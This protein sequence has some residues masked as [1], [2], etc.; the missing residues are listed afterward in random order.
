MSND[1]RNEPILFDAAGV[2]RTDE[3]AGI[4][5]KFT[6][7]YDRLLVKVIPE[8]ERTWNG[9]VMPAFAV[10]NCPHLRGEVIASG[11]GRVTQMGDV[12][13]MTIKDGDLIAFYRIPSDQI[14]MP[15][16]P[17]T[18]LM[19]IREHHVLGTY[20]DLPAATGVLGAD[21]RQ[22]VST[23]PIVGADGKGLAS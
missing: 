13:P 10:E 3:T 15:S 17:G 22:V 6:P 20:S 16:A 4:S 21:G 18:E 1:H 5:F 23:S 11:H 12:V 8:K 9:L 14:I 19:I 2:A 7:I